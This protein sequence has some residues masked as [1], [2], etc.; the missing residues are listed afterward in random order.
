MEAELTAMD[1]DQLAIVRPSLLLGARNEFRLGETFSTPFAIAAGPL[2]GGSLKKY[3]PVR[4]E[5]VARILI[6]AF[7]GHP[8]G[9]TVIHPPEDTQ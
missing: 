5:T 4:G 6:E 9:V 1:F 8:G 7:D 2:L 3:R